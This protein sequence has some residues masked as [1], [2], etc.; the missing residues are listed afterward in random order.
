[1]AL[2]SVPVAYAVDATRLLAA[3]CPST[4]VIGLCLSESVDVTPLLDAG[5]VACVR[6][7]E[8]ASALFAAI[9]HC[10]PI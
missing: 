7:S 5:A 10:G 4:R 8:D 1:M 3:E 9:R 6:D 2:L